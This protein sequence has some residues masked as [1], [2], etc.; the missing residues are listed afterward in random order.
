MMAGQ[1]H[2]GHCSCIQVDMATS[3]HNM[4]AES[5]VLEPPGTYPS[6]AAQ[7]WVPALAVVEGPLPDSKV[8]EG[9]E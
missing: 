9:A 8:A 6:Y 4:T 7:P 1:H 3:D 5:A 2:D